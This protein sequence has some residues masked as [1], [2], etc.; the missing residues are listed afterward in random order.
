MFFFFTNMPKFVWFIKKFINLFIRTQ[1]GLSNSSFIHLYV[2]FHPFISFKFTLWFLRSFF[3][4]LLNCEII[5][6]SAKSAFSSHHAL[7]LLLGFPWCLPAS[8]S[9]TGR[10]PAASSPLRPHSD[11]SQRLAQGGAAARARTPSGSVW[12]SWRMDREAAGS[13]DCCP[14]LN[15]HTQRAELVCKNE[16]SVCSVIPAAPT[17]QFVSFF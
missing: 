13:P 6:F 3:Y 1:D 2:D 11:F 7:L 17:T 8:R 5:I 16:F 15:T 10:W 12:V 9:G 14:H 4:S